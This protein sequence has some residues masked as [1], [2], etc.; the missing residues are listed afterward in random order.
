MRK[1]L[2]LFMAIMMVF[3]I[4]TIPAMA[5]KPLPVKLSINEALNVSGGNIEFITNDPYPWAVDSD[6][7]W[8]HSTNQGQ[9][10]STSTVSASVTAEEGDVVMFDYRV[11][12]EAR[13]DMLKFSIDGE[14]VASSPW[15]LWSGDLDWTNTAFELTAGS[16]EL[17]WEF[18][19]DSS[20]NNFEDTAWLDNVYVGEPV[21]PESITSSE[22]ET[23]SMGRMLQLG[24]T[25]L[26]ENAY[27]KD[28]TFTSSN[29][30]IAVVSQNGIVTGVAVGNADITITAV[31]G[32]VSTVCRVE[33][34][35]GI[36]PVQF[37]G[38]TGG[39][40]VNFTD[41]NPAIVN[42][43][44]V[45]LTIAAA[46]F[47]GGTVYGYTTDKT[48]F[49]MDLNDLSYTTGANAGSFTIKD[50]AFDH[51][52][53]KLYALASNSDGDTVLC[54]IERA[55]GAISEIAA[56]RCGTENAMTLAISAEGIAYTL[57]ESYSNGSKL[58][59]I[60][61]TTGEG[62]LIGTTG[63]GLKRAQSMGFDHNTNTL[64]WGRFSDYD[65]SGPGAAFDF[66]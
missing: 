16:H 10:S 62:S 56:V 44:A 45:D 29:P 46:E 12:C 41:V 38:Y 31:D 39:S 1:C 48:Y 11:S 18:I 57:T 64:Y 34:V 27:N 3:V 25:V 9:P 66:F 30:E 23:V 36:P 20:G 17:R 2:S 60:D 13:W 43:L 42:P 49:I 6:N 14:C 22:F 24:W 37:Y 32:G 21:H 5:E 15:T 50:M 54:N 19:K 52:A 35:E 53:N 47:A 51:S 65:A 4:V 8:A 63:M 59:R 33:V 58:Y 26:P 7:G 28:V 61:L 40:F 55:T